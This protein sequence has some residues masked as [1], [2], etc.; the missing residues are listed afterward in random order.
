[1]VNDFVFGVN[2]QNNSVNSDSDNSN[3]G[4]YTKHIYMGSQRI[5]SKVG[6]ASEMLI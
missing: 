5:T 2:K 1:M 6:N 4:N 3:G